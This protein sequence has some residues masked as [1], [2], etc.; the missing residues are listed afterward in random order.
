MRGSKVKNIILGMIGVFISIYT[1]LIG[2]DIL[3]YQTSKNQIEKQV[4][5]IVKHVLEKNYQ[6]DDVE[7]VKQMMT[8]EI[9]SSVSKNGTIKVE[10][11][12]IDLEKGLLS[13]SVTKQIQM[14]NGKEKEIRIEKTAIVDRVYVDEMELEVS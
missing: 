4:S 3:M 6:R 13:V 7:M 12:A 1:L 11:E 10:I 9:L 2:L 8:E 14:L 5:R